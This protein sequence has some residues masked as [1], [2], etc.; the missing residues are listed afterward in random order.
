ML[1]GRPLR[2][3]LVDDNADTLN[4]LS[5]MLDRRGHDV[6]TAGDMATALQLST[7]NE[8]DL[9]ISDIEL[10]DGDGRAA[11]GRHPLHSTDPRNRPVGLWLC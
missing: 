2:I 9:I 3:L 5:I 11:H 10:P 7:K 6:A 8:L 4:F 1:L